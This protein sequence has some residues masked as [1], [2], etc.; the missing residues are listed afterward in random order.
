MKEYAVKACSLGLMGIDMDYFQ[1]YAKVS[2]AQFGTVLS[3]LLR[4][5]TY[6]G[7]KP[8]YVKHLEALQ[9]N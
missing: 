2:R 7:G 1:P 6:A 5:N 3:R 9:Q 8:Y 4:Q